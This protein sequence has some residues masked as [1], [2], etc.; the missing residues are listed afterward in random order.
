MAEVFLL[1][2]V[3]RIMDIVIIRRICT[4]FIFSIYNILLDILTSSD[5]LPDFFVKQQ[6]EI[7][8]ESYFGIIDWCFAESKSGSSI[9][10]FFVFFL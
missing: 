7:R 8:I 4:H 10:W 3:V 2:T 9:P 6:N 1:T 5:A